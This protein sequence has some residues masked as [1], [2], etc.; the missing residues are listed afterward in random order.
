MHLDG[1]FATEEFDQLWAGLSPDL[2]IKHEMMIEIKGHGDN[3]T[4]G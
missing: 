2:V 3:L 4:R 1:M